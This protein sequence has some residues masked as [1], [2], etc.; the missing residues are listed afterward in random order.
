MK[1]PAA[2]LGRGG[3]ARAAGFPCRGARAVLLAGLLAVLLAVP[4][5]APA[6][7]EGPASAV[8]DT[9]P[10]GAASIEDLGWLTGSWGFEEGGRRYEEHWTAPDGATMLGMSRTVAGGRTVAHEFLRI[11]ERDGRLVYT[12][13]PSGQPTASFTS[14]TVGGGRVVFENRAHDYPTRVIYERR[15]DGSLLARVEGTRDGEPAGSDFPLKRRS[16]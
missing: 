12:A 6:Q 9:L 2:I 10:T 4:A 7:A 1:P 16:P 11:D 3:R 5:A 14:V 13:W 15:Q 8:A